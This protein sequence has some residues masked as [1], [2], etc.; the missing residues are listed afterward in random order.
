MSIYGENK[1]CR[2]LDAGC[3]PGVYAIFLKTM[4]LDIVGMDIQKS[5]LDGAIDYCVNKGIEFC[6]RFYCTVAIF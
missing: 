2:I 5:L 6:L 3:G 1:G 4:G